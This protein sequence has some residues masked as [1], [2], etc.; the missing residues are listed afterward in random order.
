[1]ETSTEI[2][3]FWYKLDPCIRKPECSCCGAQAAH[4]RIDVSKLGTRE[5]STY[6]CDSHAKEDQ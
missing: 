4:Q 6:F 5:Y 3:I 1:M 2:T